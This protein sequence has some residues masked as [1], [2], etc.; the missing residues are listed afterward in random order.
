MK[1]QLFDFSVDVLQA[2]LWR[3]NRADALQS[4]VQSKQDWYDANQ[5][6]FWTAWV[7]DVFDLRTANQFGLAVWALILGIPL[8]VILDPDFST[9]VVWG[10]APYGGN[11][12]RSNYGSLSQV[13]I[14]LTLD[15]QRLVL[16]LRYLQLISRGTVP[17]INAALARL[18]GAFGPAYVIDNL[19]MSITYRFV[20]VMPSALQFVLSNFDL[21][22]RPAGVAVNIVTGV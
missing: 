11:Y 14:P 9:K 5:T 7:R 3:Y 19:D 22:P 2:L 20:F 15:Q 12:D 18:F 8:S 6:D 21:L 4:L 10:F 13:V 17:Q 16:Q 1:R